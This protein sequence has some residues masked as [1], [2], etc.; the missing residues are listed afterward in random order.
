[1]FKKLKLSIHLY[2]VSALLGGITLFL[3]GYALVIIQSYEETIR[4]VD[5]K[6]IPLTTALSEI[7]RHQL[8]QTLRMTEI[9]LQARV[10]NREKFEIANEG[11]I[12]AGKRLA[13]N[14]LEGRNIAQ[15]GLDVA[16]S[17]AELKELDAIKT[18]IKEIEKAHGDYEHLGA[19][20]VRG[21]YQ[22][23]F[24]T[25]NAQLKSGDHLSAEENEVK[26][27]AFLQS[28]LS[29]LEDETRRLETNIK[30]ALEKVKNL[31][32]TL[33]LDATAKK[34]QAFKVIVPALL[35][36][37]VLGGLLILAIIKVHGDRQ[38][39]ESKA[40][41]TSKV[42]LV[43]AVDRMRTA[44]RTL[45]GTGKQIEENINKQAEV[46]EKGVEEMDELVRTAESNLH[47]SA[48]ATTLMEEGGESI[49]ETGQWVTQVNEDAD[50][51]MRIAE[52]LAKSSRRIKEAI[53]QINMLATNASAEASR[54]EATRGFVIFTEEM[55][56]VTRAAVQEA[57]KMSDLL[58]GTLKEIHSEHR[59][60][61]AT[62]RQF[63]DI[64]KIVERTRSVL[65][66]LAGAIRRQSELVRS[67]KQSNAEVQ[68]AFQSNLYLLN[69][70]SGARS[71]IRSQISV[72]RK[73][74]GHWTVGK[75]TT[76]ELCD[77]AESGPEANTEPA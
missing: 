45:D 56:N 49:D 8:E 10:G 5:S 29:T 44:S 65:V 15:K 19:T 66:N 16:E 28:T 48:M 38:L 54:S 67:V 43:R 68:G 50:E 55:K 1:M 13:D 12:Q 26:H 42:T 6:N 27:I 37:V 11:Y 61:R 4:D 33:S 3:C 72:A 74:F 9:L 60:A 64:L 2:S 58:E 20:L 30:N 25:K 46:F 36:S 59:H 41:E 69:E 31:S 63:G 39:E 24:L 73:V 57:E 71:T 14:L 34:E 51:A 47:E 17:E 76:E 22:Y 35:F 53:L 62:R 18:S 7:S 70:L 40:L 75:L 52:N 77:E 21:I 32:Q 23:E